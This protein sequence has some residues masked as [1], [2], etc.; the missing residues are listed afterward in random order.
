MLTYKISNFEVRQF[1]VSVSAAEILPADQNSPTTT[2]LPAHR[3]AARSRRHRR[4]LRA[5]RPR[6]RPQLGSTVRARPAPPEPPVDAALRV[7]EVPARRQH[8]HQLV[9]P[10]VLRQ[11]EGAGRRRLLLL[12][13]RRR[14]PAL[15]GRPRLV[16]RHE[17]VGPERALDVVHRGGAPRAGRR[18]AAG[19]RGG[20]D[21]GDDE[22]HQAGHHG[23]L[24][25]EG[26][27]GGHVA[28]C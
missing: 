13:L 17:R 18:V 14:P 19:A 11:A 9:A 26:R 27:I 15:K 5:R 2:V 7:E 28:S 16:V 24:Q 3:G 10:G 23:D 12:P 22:H 4:A 8:P 6:Q 1:T 25:R 21:D 20:H